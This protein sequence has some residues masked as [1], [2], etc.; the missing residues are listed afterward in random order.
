[1]PKNLVIVESPAKAKTIARYLGKDFAVMS[2]FGHI[3][4]LPKKDIGVDVSNGFKPTY[5]ISQDKEKVAA[6]LRKASK[7][8]TVWLASDEDREGEAIAWH[9]CAVLDID[10]EKTKRIVFHE[11]TEPAIT[12]AVANPR[13]I[14]LKLVHA[15]QARRILDRLVGYELSPVLWKKVRTGLSAGRVQS[16]AVRLI[17]ERE[18]EIKD[19]KHASSFKVSAVFNAGGHNLEA[20]LEKKLRNTKNAREFLLSANKATFQVDDIV[21]KPGSRSPGAPFTTSTLQ[22][23]ASRRLGYSVRQTMTVAQKLYEHGHITYMRT[24]STNLSQLAVNAAKEYVVATYGEKYS[25]PTQYKTKSKSAQQAHEAIRPT[26]FNK[27]SAG[28]DSGQKKLYELIWRRAL[29]SQMT[30]A[31]VQRTEATIAMSDR[32]DKFIATGEILVFDG[33]FKVYGGGKDDKILPSIEKGQQL[34]LKSMEA[35]ETF[36]RPASRYSEASLVKKLEELGIGRPSTYAPTIGT[37]QDRGYIEKKDLDGEPRKV[38]QLVLKNGKVDEL[39]QMSTVGADK[40]KLLP[41]QLA[42]VVTDFL[43]KNF[44]SVIDYDFTANA[45]GELDDIADGKLTWKEMLDKFYKH[46]HPLIKKS[47]NVSRAE[48]SQERKLGKDPK[49]GKNVFVRYGRYGP[50]LQLGEAPKDKKD[51]EA[52]KPHFAPLPEGTTLDDVTLMQAIPMFALPRIVGNTLKDE[53]ITTNIGRFGPYLKVG[54]AFISL[55]EHD[56]LKISEAEARKVIISKQKADSK[57][58]LADYGE[59]QVLNGPYGPYV[60]DGK[61][62]VKIP[63]AT[64]PKKIT[65]KDALKLL[66][67]PPRKKRR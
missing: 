40:S 43:V 58:L 47:E 41:T 2:S 38:N 42:E 7:S 59:V 4:D 9:V 44:A 26:H 11:I 53:E 25:R 64:D 48:A 24:D 30:P 46:F 6:E 65:E 45:E 54:S 19:F 37:I 56:P 60:T 67:N 5:Q 20:E 52:P 14:D 29:A 18:R 49:S 55:K 17:V 36:T 50:V 66:A 57:K 31:S 12:A 10:P 32:T 3:R 39:S 22:Q 35:L 23:E 62:N 27:P 28:T 61:I 51:K 21:Q 8:A 15:Q 1:M 34:P 33:Y 13:T 16:V 63:K